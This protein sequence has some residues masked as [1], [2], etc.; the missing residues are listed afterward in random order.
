M[1]FVKNKIIFIA[2]IDWGMGHASRCVSIIN[3]LLHQNKIII[4]ITHLNRNYFNQHFPDLQK[5]ELP[6]YSI[7][8]SSVIP[9]WIIILMQSK[10]IKSIIKKERSLTTEII[11]KHNINLIISDNRFGLTQKNT[12]SIF[13]T[14]QLNLKTPIFSFFANKLN[15]RYIHQFNEVWVPDAKNKNERLSG[16][17][18]DSKNIKI[19]VKYIGAQSALKD[20]EIISSQQ[21]KYDILILLSGIEP[22]R[23]ILENK[24]A[25]VFKNS[26]KKII[27]VRGSDQSFNFDFGNINVINFAFGNQLKNL[28]INCETIICR[29]G[30][31]TLMDL[32]LID[33]KKIILIP[34]PGQTEQEYLA[35][36]WEEKFN[37][38][39][40]LQSQINYYNFN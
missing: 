31:S 33:K 5:I 28:I 39:V 8:Y 6:S 32:K 22:Q 37:A 29:S 38:K 13:I 12:E 2:P 19:P 16:Q 10:K 34:T 3:T 25:S 18:S 24:L 36:Y 23:K 11:K 17:L 20:L 9:V 26:A 1:E 14:H 30:Y 27:L 21:P 15:R 7:R 40:C 4:G 35:K